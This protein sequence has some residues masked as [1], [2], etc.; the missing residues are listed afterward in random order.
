[1]IQFKAFK[2]QYSGTLILDIPSFE[3]P[4]ATYWLKGINGSGKS[5]LLKSLA[6]FIPYE[7]S[8]TINGIDLQKQK[9]RHRQMVGFGE[10]AP[11]FPTFLT[12]MELI[13]FYV[14]TRKGN[15]AGCLR[16]CEELHL[17]NEALNKQTGA[18]S[19]GMLKK[20]SLVLA[21]TG[22]A[23]WILLD[24]PL[25]TLDAEAIQVVLQRI[26]QYTANHTGM[27]LTSHQDMDFP[28]HNIELTTLVAT[29]KTISVQP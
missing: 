12:G 4:R 11:V 18:Y 15:K 21:F 29:N 2:K 9:M 5:T 13:D 22:T 3:M 25:I 28:H 17:S 10:A 26:E 7:G 6:G 16:F 23:Q 8:I 19:S 27:L 1:M 20:L 24:E 14:E